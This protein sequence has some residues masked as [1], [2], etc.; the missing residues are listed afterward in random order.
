MG[1]SLTIGRI[2]GIRIRLHLLFL[3]LLAFVAGSGLLRGGL[4]AAVYALVF[5]S[6][7]FALVVL[8]ELA[9]SLVAMHFGIR[10]R[11]ITLLP[12][13]GVARLEEVPEDPKVELLV[14]IAGPGMNIGIALLLFPVL[15]LT[16]AGSIYLGLPL[17]A[18]HLLSSLFAV[19]LM[20]AFFN[21]VPAF[22]M[23]GGR[24]LRAVLAFK[25]DYLSAT[26]T[27]AR[28]GRAV[29]V[30]MGIAGIV[31][32]QWF[33]VIIAVFVFTM[34]AH[35]VRMVRLREMYRQM[36]RH[37]WTHPPV[38][39]AHR[40]PGSHYDPKEIGEAIERLIADLRQKRGWH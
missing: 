34:A 20:L 6:T 24:I 8:H 5:I 14:S 15:L 31:W 17:A 28:I 22:P 19:N 23:D 33:L 1:F 3:V 27:A 36:E 2:F 12:I 10:V 21:L 30:L 39:T 13:G 9:H 32:H 25:L 38:M 35:E 37:A 18:P 4:S 26:E 11:D 7:L 40:G 16:A 29:A